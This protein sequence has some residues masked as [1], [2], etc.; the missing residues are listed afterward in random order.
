[1]IVYGPRDPHL[2]RQPRDGWYLDFIIVGPDLGLV[3]LEVKD[4]RLKS[5]LEVTADQVRLRQT[6]GELEVWLSSD[7]RP[8]RLLNPYRIPAP[9]H[10]AALDCRVDTDADLVVLGRRA[11]DAR[12]PWQ[13]PLSQGRHDTADARPDDAQANRVSDG[14]RAA[15]PRILDEVLLIGGRRD[16]D[17]GT[18]ARDLEAPLRIEL[19]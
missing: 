11:Q 5:I 14:E 17:V 4:W 2:A 15:H 9:D 6:E 19:V 3:V 12:I 8:A 13:V 18:K 16:H 7:L 10:S 1:M